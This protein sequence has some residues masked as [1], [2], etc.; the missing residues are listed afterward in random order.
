MLL[1][2]RSKQKSY[3]EM[4]CVCCSLIADLLSSPEAKSF[5]LGNRVAFEHVQQ[6]QSA[7]QLDQLSPAQQLLVRERSQLAP[8]E[9][10]GWQS[11]E[12]VI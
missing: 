7:E 8:A 3:A 9:G 1:P 4:V 6:V 10:A 5:S 12:K 11:G 2:I